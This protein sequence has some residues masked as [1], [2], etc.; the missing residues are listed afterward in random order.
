MCGL[1]T[2]AVDR[3]ATERAR[4]LRLM[5]KDSSPES[6]VTAAA[7][8]FA[9]QSPADETEQG[10]GGCVGEGKKMKPSSL[11]FLFSFFFSHYYY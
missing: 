5:H 11:F 3:R 7:C 10:G 9:A 6:M 8:G 4:A 2:T 1:P